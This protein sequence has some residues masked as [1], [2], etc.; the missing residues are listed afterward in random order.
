MSSSSAASPAGSIDSSLG[1]HTLASS[2]VSPAESPVI[3][4][5][6]L[7]STAMAVQG[8]PGPEVPSP[9]VPGPVVPGSLVPTSQTVCDPPRQPL[10]PSSDYDDEGGAGCSFW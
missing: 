3:P 7:S 6:A 10:R 9:A 5:P 1:C 8:L 2:S 4:S